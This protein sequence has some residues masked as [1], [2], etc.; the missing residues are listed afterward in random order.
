MMR[1]AAVR[2][3]LLLIAPIRIGASLALLGASFV[4]DTPSRSLGLAFTVGA[5]FITFAAL[6]DRRSLLLRS[7][8]LEPELL[9]AEAVI[10]PNW[11]VALNAAL[12]ST[13]GLSVLSLVALAAGN[14][15]LAA[16]LAG[17]VAGLGIPTV[18]GLFPLL[19]WE[20]ERAVRLYVGPHGRRYVA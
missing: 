3:R 10:D 5:V 16:L 19:A 20:R 11:R 9:P 13:V 6:A 8:E 12:P 1:V 7:R 15:V 14:E 2:T 4:G 17:C 18:I